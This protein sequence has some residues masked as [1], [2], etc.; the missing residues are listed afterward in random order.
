MKPQTLVPVLGVI[1]F[2]VQQFL[3]VLVDPLAAVLISFIKTKWGEKGADGKMVLKGGVSD[4]D[5]KKA[6]LG[7]ISVI[8]GLVIACSLGD[9][10]VLKPSG[11]SSPSLDV[12]VTA[13]TIG[14]GT[15]GANSVLKFLQYSKDSMKPKTPA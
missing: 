10:R 2:A 3:Q 12:F 13:L 15:E 6:I 9:I 7:A 14:A 11:L 4:A 8:L 1:G 5:A